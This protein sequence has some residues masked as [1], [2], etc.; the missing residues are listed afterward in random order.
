MHELI[1]HFKTLLR[2]IITEWFEIKWNILYFCRSLKITI[3][4]NVGISKHRKY[5]RIRFSA[6]ILLRHTADET[7]HDAVYKVMYPS[8]DCL[9]SSKEYRIHVLRFAKKSWMRVS[10][11]AQFKNLYYHS[12]RLFCFSSWRRILF[13]QKWSQF[14]QLEYFYML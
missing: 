3:E 14:S 1:F 9:S 10:T 7:H 4:K 8:L 12:L 2:S 11:F 13:N 6:H 5:L